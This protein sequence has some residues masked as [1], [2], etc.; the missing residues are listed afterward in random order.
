[1]PLSR[2][3]PDSTYFDL[4]PANHTGSNEVSNRTEVTMDVFQMRSMNDSVM[5]QFNLLNNSMDQSIGS[6]A[7]STSPYSSEHTSNVPTHSP[8]SQP[9]ST[10]DAMSPAPVI[11]SNTDYPGPHHFEVTFQ[12]SST[13]KSATWTYSPLLKKLYCQIAKTCPIQIKVSTPPPPGTIIRAMPVYKKA[14]HVTEVVKRCPNHELGRDF[15]DGQSAPASHLI[16]VEGGGV[17]QYVD[18]PVT[19]RQS[20]MVPYEPPQVG[21]EFTT[22]LYNFGGDSSC[23]GGMNRRPILII[24]TGGTRDGQVLGRRSFEGRICA[25]P[26]RDRKADEDH[27]REQQGGNESAAKNGNANKRTF[28]QSPQG[29]PALGTGIKKRRQGGEEMYY[30]P[31]RGR[32]NFEILMKIKE[33][34]ELVELV[35]QQLVDSYRQQQQ[36]GGQRQT[37]L[38]TPSSYGPVLSPMNKVHGGGINKLP[39]VNQLVGQPAGGGSG[40]APS[41]GPMG[42]GMLNSHPMQPNGEMNGGHSSQPMV[43]GS[44]CTPPPPYNPDPSLVSFGG[45]LGCPNCIDYFT[46]QGLQNI[47][48]LQNLSIEDLGALKIPEQYRMII[49]RGLQE[50]KQ[51]HD[52]GAQQLIRSSSNASTISI[53]SSGELQ[54]QRVMEAV[55]FRVRHTITIPNRGGADEWADFGFDLPDC[56]SRKQGGEEEFTEGEIN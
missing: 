52:Y 16:R 27:Y 8:Y 32:E 20:V 28:K 6:R 51:S 26:G 35:P 39:S 2:R 4:P 5:S 41:L 3:E 23:V 12:Q 38:Q 25:C 53:G 40:T 18:D 48:H 19:G 9:S 55:H 22:I 54:R 33:S 14:E 17:S 31:V 1:H 37:Q 36:R 45:G 42:P 13:A 10:F 47:Y 49:W 44:H 56:K 30:V 29:I 7:A 34:L 43:S 15:N 21:T 24:I 46:S 50:L 11:P